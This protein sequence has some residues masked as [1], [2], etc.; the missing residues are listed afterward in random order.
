MALRMA[1]LK[2]V[3][4]EPAIQGAVAVAIPVTA[5]IYS[6]VTLHAKLNSLNAVM[7]ASVETHKAEVK[8]SE[9]ARKAE[10]NERK[11]KMNALEETR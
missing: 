9:E 11:A 7:K 6:Q 10:M 5:Y 8:A 3:L 1:R 4:A 2:E